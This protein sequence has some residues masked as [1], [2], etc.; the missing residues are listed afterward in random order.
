MLVWRSHLFPERVLGLF[1]KLGWH[2]C[3]CL[4]LKSRKAGN[5][6]LHL[7]LASPCQL[8]TENQREKPIRLISYWRYFRRSL[9]CLQQSRRY[10]QISSILEEGKECSL[11][12]LV[13]IYLGGFSCS[14]ILMPTYQ[15]KSEQNCLQLGTQNKIIL[16]DSRTF[17]SLIPKIPQKSETTFL[18][19]S[20]LKPLGINVNLAPSLSCGWIFIPHQYLVYCFSTLALLTFWTE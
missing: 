10:C 6:L 19:V 17:G 20:I 5:C 15:I 18:R 7:A 3:I 13:Y 12:Y 14:S 9:L 1:V 11:S 2:V 16:C 4:G 8:V